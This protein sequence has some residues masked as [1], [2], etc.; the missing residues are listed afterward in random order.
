MTDS[1]R[2][3]RVIL[4]YPESMQVQTASGEFVSF[5]LSL[6]AASKRLTLSKRDDPDW[7]AILAYEEPSPDALTVLGTLDGRAL[8][9]T[10]IRSLEPEFPLTSRGFHWITEIPF[11][12]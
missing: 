5:R 8:H 2:W 4:E 11:N 9:A 10:L 12:R 3:W 7:Q 1:T 6:D